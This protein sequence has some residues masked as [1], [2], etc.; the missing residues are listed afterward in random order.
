VHA[1]E[2]SRPDVRRKRTRW[3]THQARID[4]TRLLFIDETWLK[5]NMAPLRGWGPVGQR[6]IAHVPHGHWKT[7]TFLAA[8]RHDRIAA[9][10]VLDGPINGETFLIY[11][12]QVLLPTLKPGDIVIIDNLGSHKGKAVRAALRR[13]GAR[14]VFLPPYSPDLNPIEQVFAKLK[15]L[16]RK[17][18]C[19][20]IETA[21]QSAG[22]LLNHFTPQECANYF[23]NSGYASV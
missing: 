16:M 10:F 17:Q 2:R 20:T 12:E 9:P 3:K 6:L 1:A 4:R 18:A 5:T 14:L 19:R 23:A 7:M 15:H 8:L 22:E 11:V 13:V 21:W